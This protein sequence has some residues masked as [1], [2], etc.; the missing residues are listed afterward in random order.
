M[1]YKFVNSVIEQVKVIAGKYKIKKIILFGSRARGDNSTTSDYDIAVFG[2]NL[3]KIDEARFCDDVE[4]IKSLK[5]FDVVF[6]NQNIEDIL[7]NNIMKDGVIIYEQA[8]SE[9]K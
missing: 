7:I 1:G 2:E 5:K 9:N 8:E 6:V 4:E 3:S